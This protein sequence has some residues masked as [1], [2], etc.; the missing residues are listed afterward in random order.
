M[1][2]LDSEMERRRGRAVKKRDEKTRMRPDVSDTNG[3]E[4]DDRAQ[5]TTVYKDGLGGSVAG[6]RAEGC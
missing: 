6:K 2:Q 3:T 1:P 5:K 4:R